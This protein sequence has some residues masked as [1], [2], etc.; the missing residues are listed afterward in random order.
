MNVTYINLCSI[1]TQILPPATDR[2]KLSPG[3]SLKNSK[4]NKLHFYQIAIKIVIAKHS[5]AT[6]LDNGSLILS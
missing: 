4:N 2:R 5:E 6:N 1:F 3:L